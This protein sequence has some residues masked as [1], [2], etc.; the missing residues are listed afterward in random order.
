MQVVNLY[1]IK[2]DVYIDILEAIGGI[3]MWNWY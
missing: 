1:R 2:Q 3:W